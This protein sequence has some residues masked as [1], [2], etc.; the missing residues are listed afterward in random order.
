LVKLVHKVKHDL[1]N[2]SADMTDEQAR[3]NFADLVEPLFALSK[4]RDYVVGR[5]HYFGTDYFKEE[6]GLNDSDKRALI[7]FLKTF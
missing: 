5:G 6:P 1:V 4:C 2:A 7:E 3:Q